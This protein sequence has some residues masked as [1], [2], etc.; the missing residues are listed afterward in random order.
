M[1]LYRGERTGGGTKVWV[2]DMPLPPARDIRDFGAREFE[3][4]YEGSGPSQLALALLTDLRDGETAIQHYR[5]F[6]RT[7]VAD[8]TDDSWQFTDEALNQRIAEIEIVP[9]DLA[10]LLRKV[11]GDIEP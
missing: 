5:D 3:W 2:N 7:I 9:M 6:M 10:G 4:G 8:I 11:R 1:K